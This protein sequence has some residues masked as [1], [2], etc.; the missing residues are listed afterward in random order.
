MKENKEK[1]ENE[2]TLTEC[3]SVSE[4]P[5][6]WNELHTLVEDGVEASQQD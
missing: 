2:E 6:F 1:L 3:V 4:D 5:Y